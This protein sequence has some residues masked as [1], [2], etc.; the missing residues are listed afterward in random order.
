MNKRGQSLVIFVLILPFLA[1]LI[2]FIVDSTLSLMEKNKLDGIITS[3]IKNALKED[4]Y[5]T[6]KI[7][8]AIL[9][10]EDME[11]SV[12][13]TEDTLHVTAKSNKKSVFGEL[14]KFKY[15]QLEYDYCGNYTD[16]KINKKCG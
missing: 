12:S 16:K 14:L 11:V 4:I 15:Y 5:D 9:S 7:K 8:K 6:D 3:N 2:A 10:N 13:V 1:L